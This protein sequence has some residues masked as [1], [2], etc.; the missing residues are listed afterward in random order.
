MD[1]AWT[2]SFQ[3]KI[4]DIYGA[5]FGKTIKTRYCKAFSSIYAED[6]PMERLLSDIAVLER[7]SESNPVHMKLECLREQGEDIIHLRFFQSQK[8]VS[9]S[10]ILPVLENFG[11]HIDSA[12]S[13]KILPAEGGVFWISDIV[14]RCEFDYENVRSGAELF[15]TAISQ[16]ISSQI[17]N[18]GF[19]RLVL[20]AL[21]PSKDIVILR[22]YTRYLL[23]TAMRYSQAH[24]ERALVTYP[25]ISRNLI[26][27]FRVM[28]DPE[29]QE[30]VSARLAQCLQL[31]Q[32]QLDLVQSLDDDTIIRRVL[33]VI[34]A[35]VRTNFFMQHSG[36]NLQDYIAIKIQS[37]KLAE[38]P[39]PAP[40]FEIFVYATQFE[41]IHLRSA[42]IARGGI[43]WS[44]RPEDFRTEVLGL[45]KTQV[46]KNTI[47][48]PSGAKGGFVLKTVPSI[49]PEERLQDI[50]VRRYQSFI[51]ALLDLTDNLVAGKCV[52]PERVVCLDEADPYL[53]VAADKG[54]AAFSDVANAISSAR[55][56][57]L[58]DAFASGGATGYDHK[59]MGIT[60][61]GAWESVLRHFRELQIDI[62]SQDVTVVGIGDMSGDVF[63]NGLLY[64]KRIQLIAAFDHRHIFIDPNPNPDMSWRE[65][66]RLFKLPVSSWDDYN[67]AL[68]SDG[69]GVFKRSEKSIKLS[70]QIKQV[71]E[72][73]ED[74]LTPNELIIALLKAPVDVLFNGGVGTYVKSVN[75][76][77]AMVGDRTNDYCRVNGSD[78]RCK[79]VGEGGNLGFTQRGRIEYA[80]QD[81][82]LFTDFIDN[83]AGVDCSDHEVNLKILLD[84]EVLKGN[85]TPAKRNQLLAT[86]QDEVASLVLD[87]NHQQAL[88]LSF[89]AYTAKSNIVLH[90]EYIRDLEA[91]GILNRKVE[92]LPDDKALVERRAARLGLTR[93]ELAVLLAYTKIYL[94]EAILMSGLPED[95]YLKQV[96]ANAFPQRVREKYKKAMYAHQLQREIVATELANDLVN[97][98][99]IT[100]VYRLQIE[101]G[102]P[103]EDIIRAYTMASHSFGTQVLQNVIDLLGFSIPIEEQYDMI[104]NIRRLINISTRWF[105]RNNYHKKPLQTVIRHFRNHIHSVEG[106]VSDLMSGVTREYLDSLTE[107]FQNAHLSPDIARRIGT[108]RAIYT[109]L[110]IIEVATKNRFNLEKTAR[111]YFACGARMNL[112][113]FRDQLAADMRNNQWHVLTRLTLR[114][115]L[116]VLQ[117]A[118]TVDMLRNSEKTQDVGDSIDSWVNRNASIMERWNKLLMIVHHS[119]TVE[120]SMFFIAIR[121][122]TRLI[123][124]R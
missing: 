73:E 16:V 34:L 81:G 20:G 19:N 70:P 120:Y 102:A 54:T 91:H 121:E 83:S 4:V 17:E 58:G 30:N 85:L 9:L 95:R 72:I 52:A 103:I 32:E 78:L 59:K 33:G 88:A 43:R 18:D 113:W 35:T 12:R 15:S 13:Y 71:L 67:R 68:I 3:K 112:V 80:M 108:S 79:V 49:G 55:G 27:I 21:L 6:F 53:V 76:T 100:F 89:A 77:H 1:M 31:I 116:D 87:D 47:I 10:Y 86:L 114:D 38:L 118:L 110:N 62:Q 111:M 64:S 63:G 5:D 2:V 98:M 39:S 104:S 28:H 48:V 46:V 90:A 57:W 105:L 56:F 115:E 44:D 122:L 94:K 124:V 24:V 74:V 99:G 45:M 75:E 84:S 40:L 92:Y 11:L 25:N 101:T 97:S 14:A 50:V 123:Q 69:G 117:C 66:D 82:L 23:Q 107:K 109:A 26:E 37:G 119:G 93:P 51:H 106:L 60:A 7:L 42:R 8:L 61:R 65:R 36:E 96:I 41:A 22:V 29:H